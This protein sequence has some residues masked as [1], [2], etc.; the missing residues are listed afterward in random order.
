MKKVSLILVAILFAVTGVWSQAPNM[1]KYQAVLRDASGNI[2]AN[3][4]KTVVIDILQ[5]NLTTSVFNESHSVTTTAQGLINLN[6]GSVENL[7]GI[8]WTADEYFIQ[9]TVDGTI[10]GTSQLLSVP[11]ALHAKTAE[12]VTGGITETDPIFGASV[13][14]GITGTDTTN[15]NNKLDSYTETD[16]IFGASVAS[17][18]TATDTTNWNNKQEQLIAGTGINIVGNTISATPLAIGDSYQGGIIFWIDASGQHGLIAATADQ[19]AGVRWYAEIYMNTVAYADGVGA[20][21]ANT[22]IIIAKQGYG[23]GGT[24]AARICNEYQSGGY[25]DWYLPSEYEL[26][27]LYQQKTAVGGFATGYYWSSTECISS[28]T[29]GV[30]FGSGLKQTKVKYYASGAVRAIR[31][32]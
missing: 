1:F 9:I 32:F 11:Y 16:P 24:Y 12:T 3:Q 2:L 20:G 23:D 17:G 6:I 27:R 15:W 29:W 28:E 4:S 14:S 18:I 21:K 10:M 26:D 13:A 19:S 25:G 7:S 5:S 22:A 31:A 30:W 8:D